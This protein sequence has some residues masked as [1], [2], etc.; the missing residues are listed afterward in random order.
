MTFPK[1]TNKKKKDFPYIEELQPPYIP[2]SFEENVYM[3][4]GV[5]NT[6]RTSE[7]FPLPVSPIHPCPPAHKRCYS[8]T[9]TFVTGNSL[10]YSRNLSLSMR[11][12]G[13]TRGGGEAV[14]ASR[15]RSSFPK[16]VGVYMCVRVCV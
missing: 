5:S 14:I 6:A 2:S 4:S 10:Q 7:L 16:F 13:E 12:R 1:I 15:E 11:P 8:N 3:V 9:P